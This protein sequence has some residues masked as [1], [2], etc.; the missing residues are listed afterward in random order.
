VGKVASRFGMGMDF[1]GPEGFWKR[2]ACK[3]DP[4]HE[5]QLSMFSVG[6]GRLLFPLRA[7]GEDTPYLKI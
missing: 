6:Y 7:G 2:R 4:S 1:R 5:A 3:E